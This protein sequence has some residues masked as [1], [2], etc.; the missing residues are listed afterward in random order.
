MGLLSWRLVPGNLPV[1]VGAHLSAAGHHHLRSEKRPK[2]R[3]IDGDGG[4]DGHYV[5]GISRM[6]CYTGRDGDYVWGF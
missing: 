1:A 6:L 2:R 5:W 3:R 4:R